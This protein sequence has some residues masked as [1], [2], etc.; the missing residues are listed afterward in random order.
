MRQYQESFTA[1]YAP[2][3]WH[4]VIA[5]LLI[6]TISYRFKGDHGRLYRGAEETVQ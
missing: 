5:L 2:K 3:G 1:F 4:I 6:Y